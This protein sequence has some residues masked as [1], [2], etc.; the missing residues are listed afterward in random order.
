[1]DLP[2]FELAYRFALHGKLDVGVRSVDSRSCGMTHERHANFLQDAG[3]HQ[4]SVEGV[5]EV[6]KAD[7]ADSS[8]FERRLPRAF[9]D[10]D[11]LALIGDDE[12]FRLAA[13]EQKLMEP[14]CQWDLARFSLGCLRVSDSEQLAREVNVLPLLAGNLAAAHAGV[15]CG[16]GHRAQVA[17]GGTQNGLFLGYA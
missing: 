15:E 2:L 4:A 8:V 3:L 14:F 12:T 17:G 16:D 5:A 13:L 11:R 9:D 1:M 7:V 10:A 6:M